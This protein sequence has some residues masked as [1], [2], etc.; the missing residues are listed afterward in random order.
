MMEL[1]R[2][3][4]VLPGSA[5]HVVAAL[6]GAGD[7][8]LVWFDTN[9]PASGALVAG[10]GGVV[11]LE[12]DP[13]SPRD[14]ENLVVVP[15]GQVHALTLQGAV[16]GVRYGADRPVLHRFDRI[17]TAGEAVGHLG[18]LLL[19]ATGGAAAGGVAAVGGGF[20]LRR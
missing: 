11:H 20:G 8:P 17:G 12:I 4:Q 13:A 3:L 19:G 1:H 7:Q 15:W 5:V 18:A 16:V 10:G 2:R 14:F 6:L 9:Y